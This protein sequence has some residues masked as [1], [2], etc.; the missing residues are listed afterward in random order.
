MS[1]APVGLSHIPIPPIPPVPPLAPGVEITGEKGQ[2]SFSDML[3]DAIKSVNDSKQK[4]DELTM[5]FLTG[6]VS[7][8][9]TV[10]IALQESTLTMQLAI[11]IR[12]KVI[13]AYQEVSRMQV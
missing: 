8:Y 9:H 12:N 13:E 1:V 2:V 3:N 5:A 4:A 10:A 11:E 6:E 7:D